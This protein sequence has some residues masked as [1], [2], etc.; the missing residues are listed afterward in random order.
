[1]KIKWTKLGMHDGYR[2]S[3]RRDGEGWLVHREFGRFTIPLA[4]PLRGDPR[5]LSYTLP[6]DWRY[7]PPEIQGSIQ[8]K[9]PWLA[10]KCT[11]G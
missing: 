3:L 8:R 6:K 11:G 9:K 1:M 10:N 4:A 2:W 7:L 5:T